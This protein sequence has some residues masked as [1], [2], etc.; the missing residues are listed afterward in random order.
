MPPYLTDRKGF[1]HREIDTDPTSPLRNLPNLVAKKL[2]V[3]P[4]A[5]SDILTTNVIPI[6]RELLLRTDFQDSEFIDEQ[7]MDSRFW[8]HE[9]GDYFIA[10]NI[11]N[12]VE[13]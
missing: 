13:F 8:E 5:N 12:H 11:Q 6:T 2:D 9:S 1:P 7:S 3:G 4:V 10:G